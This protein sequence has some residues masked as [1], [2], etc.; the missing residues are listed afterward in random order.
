MATS[1]ETTATVSDNHQS[2]WNTTGVIIRGLLLNESSESSTIQVGTQSFQIPTSSIFAIHKLEDS[3]D[4]R[5][6]EL[7]IARDAQLIQLVPHMNSPIAHLIEAEDGPVC[8]C[9]CNCNCACNCAC[10]CACAC[11]ERPQIAVRAS[12]S[13]FRR[14]IGSALF[15]G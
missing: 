1:S 3:P 10:D 12:A 13:N 2:R 8:K 7:N 9:A 4:A 5:D 14:S 11:S 6:V 15:G